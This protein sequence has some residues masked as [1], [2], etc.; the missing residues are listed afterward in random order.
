[1]KRAIVQL[2]SAGAYQQSRYHETPKL[3]KESADSYEDRTWR[4]RT[5]YLSDGTVYIPAVQFKNAICDIAQYLSEKIVGKGNNT[6]A[7]HFR[8]GIRVVD[9]LLLSTTKDEVE[10]YPQLCNSLGKRGQSGSKVKKHFPL[11]NSWSGEV[12]FFILDDEITEEIFE[13]YLR[14]AGG[15]IGIGKERPANGG[16]FGRF[17]VKGIKWSNGMQ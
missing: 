3:P 11:I 13:K 4:E 6:W 14:E 10:K 1:M 17:I 7:K 15:L 5:H 8:A 9:N 12:T 2:E 16:D